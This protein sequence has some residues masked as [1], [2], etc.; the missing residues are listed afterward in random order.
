MSSNDKNVNSNNKNDAAGTS[1]ASRRQ[2]FVPALVG[3][4]TFV[5]LALITLLMYLANN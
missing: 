1:P 4:G 5:L 2:Q 3:G